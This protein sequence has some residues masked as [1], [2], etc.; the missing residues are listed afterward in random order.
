MDIVVIEDQVI[1]AHAIKE[2]FEQ[3]SHNA[4]TVT[5]LSDIDEVSMF[6]FTQTKYIISDLY[7]GSSIYDTFVAL[8]EIKSRFPEISISVFTQSTEIAMLNSLLAFIKADHLFDKR[9][10]RNIADKV[11][12]EPP[13]SFRAPASEM[14]KV[15][16]LLGLDGH[17]KSIF[18]SL[19]QH[20]SITTIALEKSRS[21]SAISQALRKAELKVGAKQQLMKM[22]FRD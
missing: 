2:D 12:N 7:L 19:A 8:N 3:I 22:F 11:L 16:T 1:I 15:S 6:D 4:L 20:L 18:E 10:D 9:F 17:T 21:K 14:N 5:I 13:Q